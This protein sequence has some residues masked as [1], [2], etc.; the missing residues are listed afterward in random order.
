[1]PI[2]H[3]FNELLL[4][5]D[6]PLI[7]HALAWNRRKFIRMVDTARLKQLTVFQLFSAGNISSTVWLCHTDHLWA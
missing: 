7:E 4:D 1:M 2:N 3:P 5:R 6:E